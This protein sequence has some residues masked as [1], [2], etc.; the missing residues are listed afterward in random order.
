MCCDFLYNFYLKH[1]SFLVKLSEIWSNLYIGPH[2]TY[3]LLLSDFSETWI[4][5][6]DLRNVSKYQIS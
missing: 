1:F 6:T 3:W 4:F 5:S 2:V